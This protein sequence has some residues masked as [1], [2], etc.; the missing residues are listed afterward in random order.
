MLPGNSGATPRCAPRRANRGRVGWFSRAETP[1]PA[2]PRRPPAEAQAAL[3]AKRWGFRLESPPNLTD[4]G[5]LI[6]F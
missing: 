5:T 6:P 2:S 1:P 3:E 4:D